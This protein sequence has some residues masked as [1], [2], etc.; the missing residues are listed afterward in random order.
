M[1]LL[2]WIDYKNLLLPIIHVGTFPRDKMS[3]QCETLETGFMTLLTVPSA[4][5]CYLTWKVTFLWTKSETE[6]LHEIIIRL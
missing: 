6:M 2:I 3:F 1:F 4:Y 5:I